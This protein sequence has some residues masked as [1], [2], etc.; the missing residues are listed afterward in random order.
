MQSGAEIQSYNWELTN[1]SGNANM[2]DVDIRNENK[3]DTT[4]TFNGVVD[5]PVVLTFKLTVT[6]G[7]GTTTSDEANYYLYKAPE[8]VKFGNALFHRPQLNINSMVHFRHHMSILEHYVCLTPSASG[9]P[10]I[11]TLCT[12]KNR[13]LNKQ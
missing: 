10:F 9:S 12:D 5:E 3:A 4:F 1:V 8:Q 13:A 7:N 6:Q 11:G 2:S